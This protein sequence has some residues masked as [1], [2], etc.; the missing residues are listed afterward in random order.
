MD[1]GSRI[2]VAG[3]SGLVGSALCRRL[4]ADGYARV[5]TRTRAELD[6]TRQADVEAFFAEE[7]PEYVFLAAAKVGG[8]KA[9]IDHPAA[10]LYDN[11]MIAANVIHGAYKAGVKRLIF[12]GSTCIYPRDAAQ[13]V[14]E[15]ALMTGALEP[16]NAAYA[17]AK[18][19]G[20]QLCDSYRREHGAEFIAL[21]PTNLYGMGDNYDLNSAHV[22]PALVRKMRL[23][24]ALRDGDWEFI[25]EDLR[26][27]PLREAHVNADSDKAEIMSALAHYGV[28]GERVEIWGSGAPIRDF[29]HAEDLADAAL[30]V[31][32]LAR[33]QLPEGH[34]NVGTGEGMS[35][36]DLAYRIKDSV[37]F[38]G[39]IYFNA[40]KPDGAAVKVTDIRKLARLGWSVSCT[41]KNLTN[42]Y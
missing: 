29:M 9:N 41:M 14:R 23:G 2:Y 28:T 10:F 7:A 33:N 38:E 25:R 36:R 3:H 6:L 40:D 22:I 12:F 17:V 37:G 13:P 35:I 16:T 31:M 1:K 19:T 30:F 20:V 26:A 18:I 32:G 5:I 21:M 39:A 8:I 42:P 15:D 24:Q 11:M 27:W 4:R 34:I